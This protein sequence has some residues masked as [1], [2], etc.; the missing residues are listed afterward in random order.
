MKKILFL[1]LAL[2]LNASATTYYLSPSG[3]DAN[4]GT[5]TGTPWASPNH[6][7][8]CGDVLQAAAGSYSYFDFGNGSWGTVTCAAGNNV[9]WVKCIT[10]D[11]CKI[12]NTASSGWNGVSITASYW[13]IQGFEVTTSGQ[14]YSGCFAA[15]PLSNS[16]NIH[17]II[18]A[19]NVANGCGGDG[20]AISNSTTY[21][22]DYV[23]I[24]GNVIY[25][26]GTESELCYSGIS[27]YQ[28]LATDTL[29]GTHIY[30]AGNVS[31]KNVDPNPCSGGVPTDGEGITLDSIGD[32]QGGLTPVY[33]QQVV[34]QNNIVVGNGGNGIAVS[35]S[36]NVL[37]PVFIKNNTSYGNNTGNTSPT[38]CGD[39]VADSS[40]SIL[41]AR[42]LARTSTATACASGTATQYVYLVSRS[43]ASVTVGDNWGYSAAG[44]NTSSQS[45]AGFGGFGPGNIFGT[46]PAFVST[47]IPGAPSCGSASSALNCLATTIANFVP[48]V[49]AAQ[50]YGYHAPSSTI[51]F[52]PLFPKWLC[53]AGIPTGLV[54]M[55]CEIGQP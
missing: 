36:G 5:S 9:A 21:S 51:T 10:F 33:N 4:N 31:Y 13:G 47:T 32:G 11:A 3:S 16:G 34:V 27:I 1:L 37:A 44:N 26:A 2:S 22:V 48:T 30:V 19:N 42:N 39:I 46:D 8:N 12:S 6:A 24:I 43:T 50:A 35:G 20:I 17:H 15:S 29:P 40:N 38:W 53:T 14:T 49:V 55:G 23:A 41:F 28:P 54:T 25:G 18:F 52:D 7:V 45:N